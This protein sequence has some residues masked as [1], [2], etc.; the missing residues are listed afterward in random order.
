MWLQ[1]SKI[2]SQT[3]NGLMSGKY[4]W[5]TLRAVALHSLVMQGLRESSEEAAIELLSLMSEISPPRH[6]LNSD[7]KALSLDTLKDAMADESS[8]NMDDSNRS[9]SYLDTTSYIAN[10]ADA[11][12]YVRERAKEVAKD[13]RARSKELFSG[14]NTPSSLLAVAQSKWVDDEPIQPVLL[15]MAEF[16]SDFS[17]KIIALRAVWSAIRFDSCA[18]AQRRLL[19]QITD[20]RKSSPASSVPNFAVSQSR[21]KLPIKI[22][23][24]EIVEAPGSSKF[25]RVKIK[26]KVE[27]TD[28]SMATFFNP[29]ASKKSEEDPTIIPLGEEQYVL[30]AFTNHLSIPFEIASCK[31]EFDARYSDRIKAPA[32]SF[33]IPGQT[34]R[35]PVQFPFI[36]LDKPTDEKEDGAV[37]LE[38]NGI[39]VTTLSRSMFLKI[40]KAKTEAEAVD[41]DDSS[42]IPNPAS[43][44]PRRDYKNSSKKDIEKRIKSPRLEIVP[45]QP[46]LQVSFASSPTPIEE[47]L[48]IP[49]P[50]SDG[51]IFTLPKF[52]LWN[53]PGLGQLGKIE[54]LQISASGLPNMPEILLYDLSGKT[55]FEGTKKKTKNSNDALPLSISVNCS[56]VDKDTLNG[57]RERGSSSVSLR[58]SAA[59][60]MGAHTSS[61]T[62]TLRIRYRGKPATSS[63]EVWRKREVQVRVLRIK[64]PRISSMSF[65]CDLLWESAYSDLCR[66]YAAQESHRRYKPARSYELDLPGAGSTDDEEFVINRLGQ[67]PGIHVCGDDLVVILSVAN[68]T[69]APIILSMPD[70]STIGFD[71]SA[72][73][74]L[75]ILPGVSARFPVLLRRIERAP[76][77]CEKLLAMTRLQWRADVADLG[78]DSEGASGGPMV[79][80]NHRV[81]Q[82]ILEI[83]PVCL[84]SIIDENPIFLS[85]ICRA[86]CS[87]KVNIAN[88][89]IEAGKP[90]DVSILVDAAKWLP[91]ALLEQTNLALEFCCAKKNSSSSSDIISSQKHQQQPRDYIWI[92]QIRKALAPDDRSSDNPHVARL[93]FLNEGDYVVSACVTFNRSG[94]DD[95]T[96]EVWFAEKAAS[97]QVTPRNRQ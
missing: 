87:I 43:L 28:H 91:N 6:Q 86:P 27:Q 48:I 83:P 66:T 15:P 85:R 47:E 52:C 37:T 24:M 22:M 14:Q 81:R 2:L 45:P 25:E 38:V 51:E 59:P 71:G 35:F 60:D 84:K 26:K 64:G 68:E 12:S 56:G 95:D 19:G 41:K 94:N 82:G 31:L 49:A 40:G 17:N 16:S 54:E 69:S 33:V 88:T 89:K 44:Y 18:V 3:G 21:Q 9:D 93:V 4:G 8:N 63:L 5:A 70:G 11:R 75:K 30:V 7:L 97:I 57:N 36:V 72:M 23:S 61:C 42:M 96:K 58:L 74:T 50:I 78:S 90:V 13:A 29:Y 34:K 1:A 67:D 62:I 39:H 46:V 79:P 80:I 55:D 92:G 76:E 73:N 77:I 20:L 65:R 10:I 32:I 53:D